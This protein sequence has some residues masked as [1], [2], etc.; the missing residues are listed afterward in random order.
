[1]GFVLTKIFCYFISGQ[2]EKEWTDSDVIEKQP[3]ELAGVD[4]F[5]DVLESNVEDKNAPNILTK[6]NEDQN[7]IEEPVKKFLSLNQH[8]KIAE[9]QKK[10][11]EIRDRFKKP[12]RLCNIRFQTKNIPAF[13]DLVPKKKPPIQSSSCPPRKS[14][15]T[16]PVEKS[17]EDL[18]EENETKWH[19]NPT[20]N[21][22]RQN[23]KNV[24]AQGK[25]NIFS[26]P[27]QKLQ[28]PLVFGNILIFFLFF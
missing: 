28:D 20:Y 22:S 2:G 12:K 15:T 24:N 25:C 10:S 13:K 17:L 11:L 1:M 5:M 21:T 6:D 4:E 26:I 16:A 9:N 7:V 19:S 8:S 3:E 23:G 18:C 14:A 27:S